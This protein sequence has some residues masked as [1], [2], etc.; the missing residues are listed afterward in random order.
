MITNILLAVDG[1]EESLGAARVA[2]RLAAATGATVRLLTVHDAPGL[3]RGEPEYSGKLHEALAEADAHLASAAAVIVEVDG[4]EPTRDR[5]T[6]SP[7][8][9]ILAAARTGGH[10]LVVLGNRGR[11]R[12]AGA[13]LGSVSTAVASRANI[14][15]MIVPHHA[16]G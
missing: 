14:P 4:P 16:A 10:D 5:T 12:I 2:G 3:L 6:G 7:A 1:S 13:L 11:G 8:E 9:E 15:V